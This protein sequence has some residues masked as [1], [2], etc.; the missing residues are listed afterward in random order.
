MASDWRS[1]VVPAKLALGRRTASWGSASRGTA[2]WR[3]ARGPGWRTASWGS[4]KPVP[5]W[6]P[7]KLGS[8]TLGSPGQS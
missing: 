7:R 2:S 5:I 8:P 6:R 3:T 4:A 1:S